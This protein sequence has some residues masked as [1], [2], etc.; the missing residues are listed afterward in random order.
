MKDY[1]ELL[2]NKVQQEYDN[3][4]EELQQMP[5]EEIIERAYEKV[6]K[7]EFVCIC[8][9]DELPQLQAKA[10][11][12]LK[13]PLAELYQEWL[14]DD[15][16]LTEDLKYAIQWRAESAIKETQNKAKDCR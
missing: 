3:F 1:N 5:A 10:L 6:I 13:N 12:N 14:S 11:Y 15:L 9:Y 7:E 4:L 2:Y 8:E 16:S